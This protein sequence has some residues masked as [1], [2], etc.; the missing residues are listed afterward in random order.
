M[1]I[2]KFRRLVGLPADCERQGVRAG[3]KNKGLTDGRWSDSCPDASA[4]GLGGEARGASAS[5]DPF[6]T[7]QDKESE[8]MAKD[9]KKMDDGKME[10]YREWMRQGFFS[11]SGEKAI[12][13]ELKRRGLS[14]P[15]FEPL[16]IYVKEEE[17]DESAGRP[18]SY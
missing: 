7:I 16:T 9:V 13:A 1:G 18:P 15:G 3:E 10:I 17:E 8:E 4:H 12:S 6:V 2:P 11:A 5:T 14:V